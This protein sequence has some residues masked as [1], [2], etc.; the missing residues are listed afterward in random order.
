MTDRRAFIAGLATA[1]LV[2]LP[3]AAQA[4]TGL[5]CLPAGT[6]AEV[7]AWHRLQLELAAATNA[8]DALSKAQSE[9]EGRYYAVRPEKPVREVEDQITLAGGQ[10]FA[11]SR[12]IRREDV[13]K[14]DGDYFDHPLGQE[15]RA[16]WQ[17]YDR[18]CDAAEQSSGVDVASA[19]QM[20][21]LDRHSEAVERCFLFPTANPAIIAEK[22]K[23]VIQEYYD[24]NG[25]IA[26]ILSAMVGVG[27]SHA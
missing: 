20:A 24:D 9:A 12:T 13:E 10:T 15:L 8:Y 14:P 2:A 6:T 25:H 11:Y 26:Q 21:A 19:A 3:V 16:E 4:T 27:G 18:L 1:P 17:N 23:L 22:L 7:E 5:I